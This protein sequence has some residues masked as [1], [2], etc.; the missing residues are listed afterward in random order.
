VVGVFDGAGD[1]EIGDDD[2]AIAGDEDVVALD[3]FSTKSR[4]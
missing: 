3:D 2:A 4:R 1:A